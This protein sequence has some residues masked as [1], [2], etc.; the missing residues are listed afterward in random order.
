LEDGDYAGGSS[1]GREMAE[2]HWDWSK[3]IVPILEQLDGSICCGATMTRRRLAVLLA[4]LTP[5]HCSRPRASYTW[6]WWRGQPDELT[7][8]HQLAA[9]GGTRSRPASPSRR[10]RFSAELLRAA[11][12]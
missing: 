4:G 12:R 9:G 8:H 2:D 5:S 6:P 1:W 3:R 7:V 11:Q 10:W